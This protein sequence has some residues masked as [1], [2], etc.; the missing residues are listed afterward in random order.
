[1]SSSYPTS[2]RNLLKQSLVGATIAYWPA[3]L[4]ECADPQAQ[5]SASSGRAGVREGAGPAGLDRRDP[6]A[7]LLRRVLSRRA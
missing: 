3:S 6:E 1:M 2:R 7:G 5:L 4:T